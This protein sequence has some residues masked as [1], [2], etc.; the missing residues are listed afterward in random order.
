MPKSSHGMGDIN[1]NVTHRKQYPNRRRVMS[2]DVVLGPDLVFV[3]SHSIGYNHFE[4][5]VQHHNEPYPLRIV[6]NISSDREEATISIMGEDRDGELFVPEQRIT[7]GHWVLLYISRLVL[8]MIG[9][10][11]W[12]PAWKYNV[13]AYYRE[14]PISSS[15]T[16]K[17]VFD[18]S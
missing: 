16:A 12:E 3:D 13:V 10:W 2:S 14:G 1:I 8:A 15:L 18:G 7:P 9:T 11:D 5:T 4:I 17:V 6:F